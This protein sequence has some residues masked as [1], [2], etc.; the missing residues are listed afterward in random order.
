MFGAPE[1]FVD[2]LILPVLTVV[3]ALL[4]RLG[5]WGRDRSGGNGKWLKI[6][7]LFPLAFGIWI[8]LQQVWA[9][10]NPD[11]GYLYAKTIDGKKVLFSHYLSLILPLLTLVGFLVWSRVERRLGRP[12]SI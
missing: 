3:F 10:H 6:A 4:L 12:I 1:N 8:G 11:T 9:I 5:G 2:V 7:A